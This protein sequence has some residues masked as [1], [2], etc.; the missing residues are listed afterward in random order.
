M[1]IILIPTQHLQSC[2]IHQIIRKLTTTAIQECVPQVNNQPDFNSKIKFVLLAEFG[3]EGENY[4]QGH[5][6]ETTPTFRI[7]ART[8]TYRE[9]HFPPQADTPNNASSELAS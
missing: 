1:Y 5:F 4:V 2:T 8:P 3:G 6:T 7:A 9:I